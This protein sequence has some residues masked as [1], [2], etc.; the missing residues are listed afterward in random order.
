MECGTIDAIVLRSARPCCRLSR[1]CLRSDLGDCPSFVAKSP[2][3]YR[4]LSTTAHRTSNRSGVTF[5]VA[6][7]RPGA[8]DSACGERAVFCHYEFL[9]RSLAAG[10]TGVATPHRRHGG[11]RSEER[12]VG[13]EG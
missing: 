13:K 8:A 10:Q 2:R 9:L 1:K 6:K 5:R 11:D 3:I 4:F 7:P 12:R